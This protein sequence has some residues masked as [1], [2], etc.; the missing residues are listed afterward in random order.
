ML[1]G[2]LSPCAS[3]EDGDGLKSYSRGDTEAYTILK[4][5]KGESVILH[6]IMNPLQRVQLQ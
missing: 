5:N 2:S 1:D 6:L 3:Y 4:G